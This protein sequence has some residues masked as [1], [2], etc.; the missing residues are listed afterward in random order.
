MHAFR[1]GE[2]PQL[3][4]ATSTDAY[5]TIPAAILRKSCAGITEPGV[6]ILAMEAMASAQACIA[7]RRAQQLET[8]G[9][10]VPFCTTKKAEIVQQH[11]PR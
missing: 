2:A 5:P 4:S 9:L 8:S 7:A 6:S 1:S 10:I 3:S 11:R